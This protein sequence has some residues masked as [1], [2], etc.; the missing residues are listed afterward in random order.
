MNI[1]NT[2][3]LEKAK[4]LIKTA[5]VPIIV[6]AQNEEF[7]RK[8]LEYGKFQIL[9]SP[10]STSGKNSV[11]Q[12][13][14]G[15]NHILVKIAT[16]NN[17]AIGIDLKEISSLEKK[18]KAESLTKTKQNLKICR[19]SKTRLIVLNATIQQTQNLLQSLGASTQQ[20]KESI[21]SKAKYF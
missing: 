16:E 6:K 21:S 8:I 19:K 2:N 20:I 4:Q 11:R 9:L 13:N 18:E 17:I 1:I 7:N 5:Q 12:S 3:N 10:E 14:S 15:L